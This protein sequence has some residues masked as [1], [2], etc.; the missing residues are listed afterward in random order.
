MTLPSSFGGADTA[1]LLRGFD[2]NSQQ[3][4]RQLWDESSG[5]PHLLDAS[6]SPRRKTGYI[7]DP[8]TFTYR[9]ADNGL[10]VTDK[11]LRNYVR[12][13]SNEAAGRM[14]KE[15]QQLIAGSILLSVWYAQMRDLMAALYRTIWVLSIGGFV[16]EDDTERNLFYLFVL[17][18]FSWLDNFH[19]QLFS[20]TQPLNGTAMNRAGLY[21]QYGNNLYQNKRTEDFI[22]RGKSQARRV[23]GPNENHCHDSSDRPGCFELAG[24]GWVSIDQ[25]VPLGEATCYTACLCHVEYG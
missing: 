25:L 3:D 21:G 12:K 8:A 20:G 15:T 13:V 19:F 18:Q 14:R 24:L 10:K 23:L 16:F 1:L 17:S 6:T 7:Y 5:A 4:A 22:E 2:S 11:Q 9:R